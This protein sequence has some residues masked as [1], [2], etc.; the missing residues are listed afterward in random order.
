MASDPNW[1]GANP[2]TQVGEGGI[3]SCDFFVPSFLREGRDVAGLPQGNGLIICVCKPGGE[4]PIW[5]DETLGLNSA[6]GYVSSTPAAHGAFGTATQSQSMGLPR[7]VKITHA[8]IRQGKTKEKAGF[9][10]RSCLSCVCRE[11]L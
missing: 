6:L 4:H 1:V 10:R 3:I 9:G 8:Q 11:A 5:Q 7:V 2:P